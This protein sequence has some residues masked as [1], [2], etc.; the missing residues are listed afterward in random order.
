MPYTNHAVFGQ[1][2]FGA[3]P[4]QSTLDKHERPSVRSKLPGA[5]STGRNKKHPRG[6]VR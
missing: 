5:T 3:D 4:L 2:N 6:I 1:H